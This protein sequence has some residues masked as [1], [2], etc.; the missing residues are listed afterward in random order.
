MSLQLILGGSGSGKTTFANQKIIEE[1]LKEENRNKNYIIIVPEQYTMQTQKDI[2]EA[3]PN[4]GIMNIDVLS[5]GR[6]AYRVFGELGAPEERLIDDETKNLIIKNISQKLVDKLKLIGGNINKF[7]YISEI[8]SLISEFEQYDID[9]QMLDEMIEESRSLSMLSYKL[10]DVKL[11]YQ[12]FKKYRENNYITN[13]EQLDKVTNIVEKSKII[14]DSVIL[15]D[16]FTGFTPV[17]YRLIGALLEICENVM[18][19]IT[20]DEKNYRSPYKDNYEL[21]ATSKETIFKLRNLAKDNYI[22]LKDDVYLTTASES[23]HSLNNELLFMENNLFRYA[24]KE[25][26]ENV[27]NIKLCVCKN[28]R[29]ESKWVANTIRKMVREENYR[30]KDF[31]IIASQPEIYLGHLRRQCEAMEIPL[32]TDNKRSILLNSF[33]EY[34]RSLL[35]MREK[36]YCYESTFR[37]L[38]SGLGY[39]I[40]YNNAAGELCNGTAGYGKLSLKAIDSLENYALKKGIRGY[41][42]WSTP[43]FDLT[44]EDLRDSEI[45]LENQRLKF[46]EQIKK[47]HSVLGRRNKT[48]E[49]IATALYEFLN[50]NDMQR[51]V[52]NRAGYF[53]QEMNFAQE[54]EYLQI[55][56]AFIELLDKLVSVLREGDKSLKVSTR[57]F[58]ELLDAGFEEMRIGVIPPSIDTVI[59]GDLLRT[60]L[61]KVKVL[62]LVGANDTLLPGNMSVSGILSEVERDKFVENGMRLKPTAKELL[63][64]HKFYMYLNLTKP[65]DKI[66]VSYPSL[67]SNGKS[68]RAAYIV[69]DLKALFPHLEEKHVSMDISDGEFTEANGLEYLVQGFKDMELINSPDWM[70]LYQWYEGK[71]DWIDII[72]TIKDAHRYRGVRDTLDTSVAKGLYG[73]V[74]HNSVSRLE[75]Y[76]SCPFKYFVESGL[77]LRERELRECKANDLG[78][79]IHSALEMYGNQLRKN[80]RS[81]ESLSENEQIQLSNTCIDKCVSEYGDSIFVETSRNQYAVDRMKRL[82]HRTVWALTNQLKAGDFKPEAYEL[83]FGDKDLMDKIAQIKLDNGTEM[84]L[85]GTIDRVDTYVKDNKQYIK[86]IDYKT[87]KSEL[88]L[89]ALSE[90]LQL[91]LFIYL[92]AAIRAAENTGQ[93]DKVVIP[94]GVF[95]YKVDDPVVKGGMIEQERLDEI[96]KSL[97]LD[98]LVALE[99]WR[100]VDKEVVGDSLHI[101][102]K[103]KKDGSY[104]TTQF[105][106]GEKEIEELR[107]LAIDKAKQ[108]GNEI[109]QGNIKV[110][111]C[112]YEKMNGCGFCNYKNICGFDPTIGDY[113]YR[114]IK[115]KSKEEIVSQLGKEE[116][117]EDNNGDK[118]DEG[119]TGCD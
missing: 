66:F 86:I 59:A 93:S 114:K 53:A 102:M 57:E 85:R 78:N 27:S 67:A 48:V 33:V 73:E 22:E 103:I 88:D 111:P 69:N 96:Q 95:Y 65:T 112:T 19:T 7:G 101:P 110:S 13:E 24:N 79:V 80:E 36:N 31:A 104:A 68:T 116:G 119:T 23:R 40:Q 47:F 60:R 38:K 63:Y 87:G 51:K 56:E 32:F 2:V 5:F 1:S 46:I 30:Y 49:D 115:K 26:E 76:A 28:V 72:N 11:I 25:Y 62:F 9:P 16:G 100:N 90:G 64:Q 109:I 82:M 29:D 41:K 8:K 43:W 20:I 97:K 118:L 3:H 10:E 61:S 94:S 35:E 17:Q 21:F 45:Y 105:L 55:Y 70:D 14:K 52:E 74:L 84:N 37:F 58:I 99:S 4:K 89:A 34:I 6:L 75:T 117:K 50:S 113:K 106:I 42:K 83:K 92:D 108:F 44:R 107:K 81:W 12:E 54:K 77:K 91:Q 98:G 39:R 18:V 15:F 71:D